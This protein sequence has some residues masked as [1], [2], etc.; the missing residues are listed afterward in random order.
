MQ[1]FLPSTNNNNTQEN[2]S[3][4]KLLKSDKLMSKNRTNEV[5]NIVLRN[6]NNEIQQQTYQTNDM[7]INKQPN[8]QRT[9]TTN[10]RNGL[11]IR[12]FEL[13]HDLKIKPQQITI[14]T[15]ENNQQQHQQSLTKVIF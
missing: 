8:V 3:F 12:D 14:S 4:K 7:I 9:N 11:F 5:P 1:S 2:Q 15:Q 10:F 6:H 13:Q